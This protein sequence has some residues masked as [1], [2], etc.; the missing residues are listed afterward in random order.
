MMNVS[1]NE[2]GIKPYQLICLNLR[3]YTRWFEGRSG[4]LSLYTDHHRDD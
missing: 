1:I 3:P 4:Q 2:N